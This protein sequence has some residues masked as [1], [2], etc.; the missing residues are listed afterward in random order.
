M[1][2]LCSAD[3]TPVPS[4]SLAAATAITAAFNPS[5]S[6]RRRR[7]DD[8][9][10]TPQPRRPTRPRLPV[11]PGD[12]A[13]WRRRPRPPSTV[14]HELL[15]NKHKSSSLAG[16]ARTAAFGQGSHVPRQWPARPMRPKSP[17]HRRMLA[18]QRAVQERPAA[19]A[20]SP[21]PLRHEGPTD[22]SA[23]CPPGD[24][25]VAEAIVR[26]VTVRRSKESCAVASGALVDHA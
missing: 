18:R 22:R 1:G 24:R 11:R 3:Q 8:W 9:L 15:N 2:S 16:I 25:N 14:S 23:A 6:A 10:G 12:A 7:R 26:S 5:G 19:Y 21:R 20:E 13:P 17:A 4:G